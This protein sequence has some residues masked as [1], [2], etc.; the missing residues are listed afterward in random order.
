MR[1]ST[2]T[3]LH[4]DLQQGLTG[5]LQLMMFVQ[6]WKGPFVSLSPFCKQH[7]PYHLSTSGSGFDCS[8]NGL[9]LCCSFA[10]PFLLHISN[11]CQLAASVSC[12]VAPPFPPNKGRLCRLWLKCKGCFISEMFVLCTGY[13]VSYERSYETSEEEHSSERSQESSEYPETSDSSGPGAGKT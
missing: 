13:E 11:S 6:C 4:L 1:M 8:I 3:F 10:V 5:L 7:I 12:A 9:I 2:R